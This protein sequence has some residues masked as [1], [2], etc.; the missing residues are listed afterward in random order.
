MELPKS[1]KYIIDTLRSAGYRA[2]AVGGAV[3]DLF[4]GRACDDYDVTTNALPDEVCA[5]FSSHR[6]IETG[7]KHGTVTV[8]VDGEP[9]EV[10]TYRLDG[11]Y[12]DSRHPEQVSFTDDLEQDLLRRDFTMNAICYNHIDGFF[13]PY[14][15]R[16][17][18]RRGLIRAV[19]EPERRFTED[20]LRIL[21]AVRF[22][23]VLGFAI[24]PD[25]DRALRDKAHLLDNISRERIRV[26]LDKLVGGVDARRVLTDY[27]D[28]LLRVLPDL[29]RIELPSGF[30][31]E[32]GEIRLMSLFLGYGDGADR[33]DRAMLGLRADNRTRLDGVRALTAFGMP[34]GSRRDLRLII[35]KFDESTAERTVAL[36]RAVGEDTADAERLLGEILLDKDPCKISQLAIGG[37]ELLALG[38]RG[39][40][41]GNTLER[42]L[43]AVIDGQADNTPEGLFA[44]VSK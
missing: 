31:A 29:D 40:D 35:M 6:I 43:M 19:G 5:V 33:F 7:I 10:T 30:D 44:L 36:H 23:S 4:I 12:T 1:V 8:M 3:R 2:D 28:V 25:T 39:A 21:R 41:I 26:E 32:S 20:A 15:G 11:E 14:D 18:I 37:R 13:D 38:Y 22:S 34:Y 9:F 27:S 16:G 24:D 17:D 42:L